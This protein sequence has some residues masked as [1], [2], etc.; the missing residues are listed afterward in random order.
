MTRREMLNTQDHRHLRLRAGGGKEPHF[1]QIVA[2]EFAAA[3]SC[4]PIVFT[5]D[6]TSGAFYAGALLGLKPEEGALRGSAERGGF[7]PLSLQREA[8][9]IAD[10]GIAIDRGSE[11]FSETEGEPLFDEILQ[12]TVSLRNVQRVLG[13]LQ[14][15]LVATEEFLRSLTELRLIEAMDVSLTF[16][17]G[18]LLTLRGLYTVSTDA[19]RRIDDAAVLRLFRSGHLQLACIVATSVQQIAILA[20]IRNRHCMAYTP[21]R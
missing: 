6:A 10:A 5:K 7:N 9:F 13:Q 4:C 17:G 19:L 8:F 1:V 3:A 11:R 2:S 14:A 21:G 18:E 12:P 15:G 16:H 20:G